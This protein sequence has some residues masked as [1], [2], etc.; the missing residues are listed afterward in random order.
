M[1]KL[2]LCGIL[3]IALTIFAG[4][5]DSYTSSAQDAAFLTSTEYWWRY[6]EV[7]G[8]YEKMCFSEDLSF[9]WGCECGEPIGASD[10]YDRYAY[11][12]K[13]NT[14]KLYSGDDETSMQMTVLDYSDY[15][16]L[17]EIDGEIKDYT[18]LRSDMYIEDA[19]TYISGYNMFGWFIESDGKEAVVGPFNYDGDIEY[20]D[21]AMKAY[22]ISKEAVFYDLQTETRL[23]VKENEETM[24]V[25]Y[26]KLTRGE[27]LSRMENGFAFIWFNDA[28]E[29]EK[30][31]Y[32]G[33]VYMQECE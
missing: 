10:I 29:I 33:A 25:S 24:D 20:P 16:L 27:G 26:E 22:A 9:Y 3:M 12:E 19:E 7:T 21:N 28:M 18:Y 8:E 5:G 17:L 1:K 32:Y 13:T 6:D 31:I 4:C 15:H 2:I 23:N 11:D 14:I 30:V